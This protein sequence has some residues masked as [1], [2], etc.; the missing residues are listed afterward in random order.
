MISPMIVV[1]EAMKVR[2]NVR[3]NIVNVLNRNSGVLMAN[4]SVAGNS[5]F[6][7]AGFLV[8]IILE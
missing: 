3:A 1:M 6:F 4:V 7:Y 2:H 8:S 5:L